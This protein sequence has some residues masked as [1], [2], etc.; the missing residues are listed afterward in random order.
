ML[1]NYIAYFCGGHSYDSSER[2][3]LNLNQ[4]WMWVIMRF[5]VALTILLLLK[6]KASKTKNNLSEKFIRSR[7]IAYPDK[8]FVFVRSKGKK[9][10]SIPQKHVTGLSVVKALPQL[11]WVIGLLAERSKLCFIVPQK[12]VRCISVCGEELLPLQTR[13]YAAAHTRCILLH[14]LT[15]KFPSLLSLSDPLPTQ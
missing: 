3:S 7:R 15:P 6:E 14:T 5:D 10:S 4:I 2:L 12:P 8:C 1:C 13:T 11:S 9:T